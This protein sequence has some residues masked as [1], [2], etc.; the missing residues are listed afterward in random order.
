MR[1]RGSALAGIVSPF[2]RRR[3]GAAPVV[4]PLQAFYSSGA[5]GIHHSTD[6]VSPAGG[7]AT[8]LTNRGGSGAA[9]NA[10]VSGAPIPVSGNWLQMSASGGMPTMATPADLVGVR[11]IWAMH[12]ST[13]VNATRLF[14]GAVSSP[15]G[16]EVRLNWTSAG[17]L[18]QLWSNASGSAVTVNLGARA[19]WPT[20]PVLVEVDIGVSAAA[21]YLNTVSQGSGAHSWTRFLVENLGKG[22]S[23]GLVPM[24]GLMGDVLGVVTGRGDTTAAIAAARSYLNSRFALGLAL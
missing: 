15:H 20:A 24:E 4:H 23:S 1:S 17:V 16:F 8:A 14:G 5:I 7:P 18:A 21:C 9:Y 12:I 19:Q 6:G 22:Q 3:A 11:L 10:T 2:G 13:Y